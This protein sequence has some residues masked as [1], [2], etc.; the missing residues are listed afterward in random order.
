MLQ[1]EASKVPLLE[2]TLKELQ[3]TVEKMSGVIDFITSDSSPGSLPASSL[4]V[5]L[6]LHIPESPNRFASLQHL[7]DS[8]GDSEVTDKP[9]PQFKHGILP[10][11][12][13]T[14]PDPLNSQAIPNIPHPVVPTPSDHDLPTPHT[15]SPTSNCPPGPQT[16]SSHSNK[17]SQGNS[18]KQQVGVYLRNIPSQISTLE[19]VSRLTKEGIDLEGCVLTP[20]L[21]DTAFS[22]SRKFVR[23]SCD[24]L[25]RCNALDKALKSNPHLPWFLSLYP[26][27][28]P[29]RRPHDWNSPHAHCPINTQ[30]PSSPSD[31]HFF[32]QTPP[33]DGSHVTTSVQQF[34]SSPSH[35]QHSASR[36]AQ[37]PCTDEPPTSPSPCLVNLS[38][39]VWN[40]CGWSID[41]AQ[42]LRTN[43]IK[44]LD[45][46]IICLCETFLRDEHSLNI[47]GYSWYG[48]NRKCISKR[49]I[50]GSGGV[51]VLIKQSVLNQYDIATVTDK[52]EGIF[53]G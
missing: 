5:S 46:D 25:D 36:G 35:T 3:G 31:Q 45:L 10:P 30:V 53:S 47:E 32:I 49:A 28:R 23:V 4:P 38:I 40:V 29:S 27:R 24:S 22:G 17:T 14:S 2:R 51:G 20:T 12:S 41:P 21:Q 11:N 50:R 6:D 16:P 39:G 8:S 13:P 1:V 42:K 48:N 34:P 9:T 33:L 44:T 19:V 18:L 43:I 26:P 7:G 52:Y 15:P 37:N